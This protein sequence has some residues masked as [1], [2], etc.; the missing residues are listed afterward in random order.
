MTG[1][2]DQDLRLRD[3]PINACVPLGGGAPPNN[4]WVVP[5]GG[6]A[7]CTSASRGAGWFPKRAASAALELNAEAEAE[8]EAEVDVG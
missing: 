2:C 5:L 6:E 4:A 3:A 8:A 7:F 1:R